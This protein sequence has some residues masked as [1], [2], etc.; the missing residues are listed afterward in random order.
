MSAVLVTGSTA[1]I[2]AEIAAELARQGHHVVRHAREES[3]ATQARDAYGGAV[4]TGDLAS[5]NSTRRMAAALRDLGP[6]DVV[7]HNAGWASRGSTRPVT[8]D[9]LERTFQVNALAPYLL[10]ALMPLPPRLVYVSSDSITRATLHLD[11]LQ[12]ETA[13]TADAAYADSKL[14][15]TAIAFAIARRFPKVICNAVH[16]GW[17]RTNMSGNEAPL[18]VAEGAATPVWLATSTDPEAT[19]TGAFFHNRRQVRLNPQ[20][21]DHQLQDALVEHCAALCGAP[22]PPAGC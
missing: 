8:V 15:L 5:L 12:H 3:R 16:P 11:D 19:V 4:V 13:W 14:A 6:F 10:T 18:D 22:L 7:V 21:Y 9:G 2:G 17:V 20:A 1:G